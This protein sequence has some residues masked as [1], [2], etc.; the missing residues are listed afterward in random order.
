MGLGDIFGGLFGNKS[1]R[2]KTTPEDIKR[3]F[4]INE[5]LVESD[6]TGNDIMYQI[7]GWDLELVVLKRKG[8]SIELKLTREEIEKRGMK[9]S[10]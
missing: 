6:S 3:D 2:P 1:K 8:T 10:E 5:W 9:L 4:P 7:A